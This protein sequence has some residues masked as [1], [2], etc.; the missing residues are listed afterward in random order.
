MEKVL[1]AMS[2]GVDSSVT[3]YLLQQMGCEL[4]GA[5][6]RLY[7]GDE[8][9]DSTCCSL[10]DVEDARS[11]AVRLGIPFYVFNFTDDFKAAVMDRFAASYE[12]GE[13][14][15][16]CIECNRYM[17]FE[18]LLRRAREIGCDAIATG[19][20]ARIEQEGDRWLLKKAADLSKDQSYV[21]Y[22]L[23]QDQLAHTRFPLGEFS[24][25]E[26]REIAEQ[27]GFLNARK[28]DSQDICF[29]PDGDYAAVIRR[30]TG[31]EYPAGAFV[32]MAG[33]RL[34]THKGLIHYT[35]GQRKGLG[36]SLPAPL[37]VCEKRVEDNTVVLGP[38]E[39]LFTTELT[40]RDCNWIRWET[41]PDSFRCCARI[42]YQHAEQPATVYAEGDT[43]RVVFDRPQRAVAKGQA[44][45]LYD[46]D[47][48][49]GG[50]TIN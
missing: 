23:T 7:A 25:S 22:S 35:I 40:A 20:Y 41:P 12:R 38:N 50:G 13:T 8:S 14:P 16:P 2:G 43:M 26:A 33:N 11:V 47:T 6:M 48:V 5:T 44:V 29:V 17:K 27:Q 4:V 36:L 10:A 42:R 24:K 3:A 34:G 46:G 15:N 30:L 28:K 9:G 45:V 1:V 37:Y 18:R 49:L 39:S 31:R 32:D 19:H 21:L